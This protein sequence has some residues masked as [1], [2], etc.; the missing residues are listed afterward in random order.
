MGYSRI[1]IDQLVKRYNKWGKKDL[2][3]QR[4]HNQ[5]QSAILTDLQPAQLWQVLSEKSPDGGLWN[6]RKVGDWL[7][8]LL[9]DR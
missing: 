6:G 5:G 2:G 8:E 9:E 1:W 3:E 7:S 4:R